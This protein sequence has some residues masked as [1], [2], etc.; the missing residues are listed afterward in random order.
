M[1]GI[2]ELQ[3]FGS[4]R[5]YIKTG[6]TL[7]LPVVFIRDSSQ[8]VVAGSFNTSQLNLTDTATFNLERSW[9]TSHTLVTVNL[10]CTISANSFNTIFGLDPGSAFSVQKQGVT[11][12]ISAITFVTWVPVT[13]SASSGS[14][15]LYITAQARF[16]NWN[17]LSIAVRSPGTFQLYLYDRT[18]FKNHGLYTMVESSSVRHELYAWFQSNGTVHVP[19][20]Y[21]WSHSVTNGLRTLDC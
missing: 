16:E 12:T 1:P 20:G 15:V 6:A 8:L 19:A 14:V 5:L 18:Y 4:Q 21:L 3:M 10:G 2:V 13:F 11:L 7:Q 9:R 17:T